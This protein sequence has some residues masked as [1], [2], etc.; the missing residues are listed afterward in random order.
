SALAAAHP[1]FA[2]WY[3]QAKSRAEAFRPFCAMPPRLDELTEIFEGGTR[4]TDFDPRP[5]PEL[6]YTVN[7]WNGQSDEQAAALAVRAGGYTEHLPFP[8]TVDLKLHRPMANNGHLLNAE[9]L[10]SVL[11]SVAE[12]WEPDSANVVTWAYWQRLLAPTG[13]LPVV[14]SGWMTYLCPD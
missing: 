3:R 8:N 6:G 7:A 2:Q 4:Y 14:R 13:R 9:V 1:A 11:L 12:A 10:R 5:M